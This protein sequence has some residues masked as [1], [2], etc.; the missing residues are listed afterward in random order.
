MAD[1]PSS[2]GGPPASGRYERIEFETHPDGRP[3]VSNSAVA[4]E[5]R[6]QGLVVSFES[7]TA[8]ATRPHVLDARGYLPPD[9]SMHALS[10]PLAGDRGLEVG[11]IHLDFPGRPRSVTFT[12]F[13]PDLIEA[14]EVIV[15][16]GGERLPAS[17]RTHAPDMRYASEDPGAGTA[18]YS[19]GGRSPFRAERVRVEA[20]LGVDRI[21]LDGWGPPGHVLLLD[22]LEIDP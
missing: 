2:G 6:E 10:F 4:E 17:A 21:S 13:G 1:T 8:D 20:P 12:L 14:F 7:Y 9:A 11:V 19:P 22:H 16:S 18:T 15:W 3:V 5:W